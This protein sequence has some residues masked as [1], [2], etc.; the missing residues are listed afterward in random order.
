LFLTA[1]Q[2][3][4]GHGWLPQ[5]SVIEF[6]DNGVIVAVSDAPNEDAVFYEGVLVPGFV[7]AHC[8]L[9][10]SHLKGFIPEHTGLIP[11]LKNIP[12][13]RNDFTDEQKKIARH[14]AYHELLGNGVVAIGDIVNTNESLDIRALDKLNYY[15]FVES[16]GFN[17]ANA[18]K[19]FEYAV[20]LYNTFAAQHRGEKLLKQ[21]VVPHAPYSVSSSLFRLIDMH[22]NDV[23]ISI[24]NQESEEENRYYASKEGAV[25]DL[26]NSLGIDDSFFYPTGRSSIQS[27]LEWMS[28]HHPF[29]FVHN[30]YT[31]HLDVQ[32]AHSR[33]D[34]VYWC[35]CP[36]ANL[37]IENKLPDINM[38]ISEGAKICIGT[39]S[40]ASN[41]Q[42]SILAELCTIRQRYPRIEWETLLTWATYNGAC[43]LQM[44][45]VIGSI[46]VDKSPGILQL[47]GLEQAGIQPSVKRII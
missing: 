10:L 16:I 4:N 35:L 28:S 37:Y 38:F 25:L 36:N 23:L 12:K 14:S 43:A 42:L 30:T 47:T 7:N 21:A 26:F 45:N 6:A 24:H 29:I 31:K 22:R 44:K 11:F 17:E 41:H 27:Y 8:H 15:T 46:E 2:I 33:I 19:S 9:E 34:E 13:H 18:E 40:L 3:H 32:Y 5:G 20:G 1:K 39:D